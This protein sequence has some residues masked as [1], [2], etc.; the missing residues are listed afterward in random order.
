[1]TVDDECSIYVGGLPYSAT[2][3]TLRRVFDIYGA[4]VDTKI[5]NDRKVGG[6]CYGFVTF[7]NPRSAMHA[8]TEMDGRTVDGRVVKVNEVTTR[9]GR[10]GFGR[11][12]IR[13]SERGVKGGERGH[14]ER[15]YDRDENKHVDG[16]RDRSQDR[17]HKRER[18]YD[19]PHDHGQSQDYQVNRFRV[20][21]NERSLE[22][23]EQDDERI[24]ES[25]GERERDQPIKMQKTSSNHE[26]R[27]KERS[28]LDDHVSREL[29]AGSSED[30]QPLVERQVEISSRKLE[31]LKKEVSLIEE[32]VNEKQNLVSKLH[33]RSKKLEDTLTA[34]KNLTT[35]RQNQLSKL[36]KH[37]AEVGECGERLKISEQELQALVDSTMMEVENG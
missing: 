16:H 12:S 25:S 2:E 20:A 24:R 6:K 8:I 7:T 29:S 34:A 36:Y 37:Y 33:E 4:I 23:V 31:K 3:D 18:G 30:D 32:L 10:S 19:R 35:S 13:H 5:I 27:D 14:W 15:G 1:M 26:R 9:G 11:E 17:D 21:K 28:Y 22:D